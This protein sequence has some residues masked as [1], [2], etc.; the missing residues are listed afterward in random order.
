[1]KYITY[2]QN[3][4]LTCLRQMVADKC[5]CEDTVYGGKEL[6][7]CGISNTSQG[8]I[9]LSLYIMAV[10][11]CSNLSSNQIYFRLA[12]DK[13]NQLNIYRSICLSVCLSV[14]LSSSVCMGIV[15]MSCTR[16]FNF[17]HN[18]EKRI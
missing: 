8:N 7:R 1:M 3:C 16:F 18:K 15:L 5:E 11:T 4:Q 17:G 14:C 9:N 2:I 6:P 12:N 10:F 13:G